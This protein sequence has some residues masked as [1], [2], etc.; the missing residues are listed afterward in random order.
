MGKSIRNAQNGTMIFLRNGLLSIMVSTILT[1]LILIVSGCVTVNVNVPTATNSPA[2]TATPLP[3]SIP[4]PTWTFPAV[5]HIVGLWEGSNNSINYSIQ[6]LNDGKLIYNEDGNTG[7][8]GW[9]KINEKQYLMGILISDTIITLNDNMTQFNWSTKGIN[10]T[11][12]T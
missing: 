12:K 3:A 5:D 10:F 9:Q 7:N 2:P 4:S 6:F 8:G 1:I 11:K